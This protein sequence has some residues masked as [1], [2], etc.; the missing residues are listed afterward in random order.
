MSEGISC[1]ACFAMSPL[2]QRDLDLVDVFRSDIETLV[3]VRLGLA[4]FERHDRRDH[5][6]M[7]TRWPI[8]RRWW[9]EL[10][11]RPT[12]PQ[13]RVAAVTDDL[14][15]SRD[16]E[17]MISESSLTTREFVGLAFAE[18]GLV[19]PEPPVEHYREGADRFCF[20][21]PLDLALLGEIAGETVRSRVLAMLDGYHRCFTGR[22][23]G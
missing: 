23:V 17:V 2:T 11:V 4:R 10:A 21:T 14:M 19:W 9:L 6:A 1:G 8:D 3:C 15:R 5:W 18:A 16:A 20:A 22:F 7:V 12:V 13:I